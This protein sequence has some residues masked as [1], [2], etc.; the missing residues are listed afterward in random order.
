MDIVGGI[1]LLGWTFIIVVAIALITIYTG[2]NL[3]D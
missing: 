1:A 2:D 3:N